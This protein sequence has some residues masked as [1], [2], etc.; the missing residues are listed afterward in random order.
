METRRWTNPSLPQT[1]QIAVFLLYADAVFGLLFGRVFSILGLVLVVGS[2][3]AGFGIAN[4]KKWG[5]NL[6]VGVSA[7]YLLLIAWSV[8]F[9][10][11]RLLSVDV[12]LFSLFPVAQFLLLVHPMSRDHQRIW[13]S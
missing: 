2:A 3:A 10:I 5:Y 9:D 11:G 4:E 6:G 1:L 7:V 12:I 8:G 13:F